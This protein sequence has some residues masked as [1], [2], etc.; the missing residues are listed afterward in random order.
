VRADHTLVGDPLALLIG[1]IVSETA[2]RGVRLH[3][4][5]AET[6]R[7]TRL[8][9][10]LTLVTGERGLVAVAAANGEGDA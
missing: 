2:C 8:P 6:T 5:A 7:P 10:L 1:E 4:G 9:E 3:T